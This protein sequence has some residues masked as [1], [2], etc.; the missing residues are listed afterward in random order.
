MSPANIVYK[1]QLVVLKKSKIYAQLPKIIHEKKSKRLNHPY[2]EW[3]NDFAN[4]FIYTKTHNEEIIYHPNDDRDF[5]VFPKFFPAQA[6]LFII[7]F[8]YNIIG[9]K[10]VWWLKYTHTHSN[11]NVTKHPI[12]YFYRLLTPLILFILDFTACM[13]KARGFTLCDFY[14][15]SLLCPWKSL[16]TCDTVCT[17]YYHSK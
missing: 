12:K 7:E 9:D 4:K 14:T 1:I 6:K 2:D 13:W 5:P 15:F 17:G 16:C 11:S 10:R 8:M 3:H